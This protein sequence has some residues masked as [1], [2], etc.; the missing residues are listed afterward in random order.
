MVNVIR[1]ANAPSTA[2]AAAADL[3]LSKPPIVVTVPMDTAVTSPPS[4][5]TLSST[6]LLTWPPPLPLPLPAPLPAPFPDAD[7]IDPST[8]SRAVGG[9]GRSRTV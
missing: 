2:N 3:S 5:P 6:L 4:V 9:G 7:E 8:A 1:M